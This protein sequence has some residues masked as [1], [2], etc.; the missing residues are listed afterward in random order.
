MTKKL[1][2]LLIRY[3]ATVSHT[4]TTALKRRRS[5]FLAAEMKIVNGLISGQLLGNLW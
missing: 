5:Y 3:L 2:I 4:R 1:R